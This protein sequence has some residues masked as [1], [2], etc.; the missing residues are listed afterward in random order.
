MRV[1]SGYGPQENWPEEKRM[2]LFIALETEIEKAAL[3]GRSVIVEMDANA[4]LGNKYIKETHM[5]CHQ[6]D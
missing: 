3:A 4:K 2:P 1:I 5:K 6:M